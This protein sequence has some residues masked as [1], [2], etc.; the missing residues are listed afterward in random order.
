MAFISSGGNVISFAEYEDV[1]AMDQRLFEANEFGTTVETIVEDALVRGT[2]RILA[3]IRASDWWRSYYLRQV[4]GNDTSIYTSGLLSVPAPS[5]NKIKARQADFTD[6]A[7]YYALAEILLPKVADFGN[8]DTAERQKIGFY[9][10]KFRARMKELLDAGDWYDFSGDNTID[11]ME[12]QPA[13]S[14]LVRIR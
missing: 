10:E 6:L 5:A 8:A 14:N 11:P 12:K 9:D 2:E 7:C 4:A 3:L 1:L 13:K